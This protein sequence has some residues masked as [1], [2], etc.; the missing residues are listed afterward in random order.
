MP[1]N[2]KTLSRHR[3]EQ[4]IYWS[5]IGWD[6]IIPRNN[7]GIYVLGYIKSGTNWMCHLISGVTGLKDLEP[8][9]INTPIFSPCIYHMH[10]FIPIA[11]ARKR[12]V[13]LM[14]DGRDT[15]ISAYFH[16]MRLGGNTFENIQKYLNHPYDSEHIK[17]NLPDFI[18]F[19]KTNRSATTDYRSHILQWKKHRHQYVTVKYEDLLSDT[20]AVLSRVILEIT[21]KAPDTD[22]IASVV[23]NNDFTNVRAK[24]TQDEKSFLRKGI[25][26]DWK[27]YFD[28]KSARIFNEYAGD[29]L[30]ELGYETDP[31]WANNL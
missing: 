15:M 10:R 17:A 4:F 11:S 13:Y 30:L 2:N 1:T 21:G 20:S 19:M 31:K 24:G 27:N 5:S 3:Y 23:A 18:N 29:L 28:Q 16:Y 7:K 22:L 25:S 26:G 6:A 9:K 8:W 12:T 14:R